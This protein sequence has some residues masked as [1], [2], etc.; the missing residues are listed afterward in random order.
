[1]EDWKID[2]LALRT[3]SYVIRTCLAAMLG[4]AAPGLVTHA[5]LGLLLALVLAKEG[6]DVKDGDDVKRAGRVMLAVVQC[7]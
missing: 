7:I 6:D 5:A 1:M 2:P 3:L 4:L